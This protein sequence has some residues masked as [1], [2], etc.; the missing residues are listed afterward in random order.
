MAKITRLAAANIAG[1]NKVGFD[2]EIKSDAGTLTT[3]NANHE[4][5]ILPAGGM[6]FSYDS[7]DLFEPFEPIVSSRLDLSFFA[8]HD[9]QLDDIVAMNRAGEKS[10]YIKVTMWKNASVKQYWYGVLVPEETSYEVTDGRTLVR[11]KF[12]D[13][14]KMLG[15][16]E[17]TNNSTGELIEGWKTFLDYTNTILRKIPWVDEELSGV[18]DLIRETPFFETKDFYDSVGYSFAAD[19]GM[20]RKGGAIA[21]T[22]YKD[23][24]KASDGR[25]TVYS[26]TLSCEEV[27]RDICLNLGYKICWNGETFHFF[28]PLNYTDDTQGQV[29]HDSIL[30]QRDQAGSQTGTY[31][32]FEPEWDSDQDTKLMNGAMR[33]FSNC[34][35]E[36]IVTHKN[37]IASNII[38]SQ[39]GLNTESTTGGQNAHASKV[40]PDYRI[41]AGGRLSMR[42][43]A[44][45]DQRYD[46]TNENTPNRHYVYFAKVK[47]KVGNYYLAAPA[48]APA[49]M[50]AFELINAGGANNKLYPCMKR[51]LPEAY[52]TTTESYID[53]PMSVGYS[54][55]Q[56]TADEHLNG[57]NFI[58]HSVQHDGEGNYSV[59]N[60]R[61]LIRMDY[62]LVT[63]A[64]PTN[65]VGI[66]FDHGLGWSH[67][68]LTNNDGGNTIYNYNQIDN[69]SDY[70]T[71]IGTDEVVGYHNQTAFLYEGSQSDNP[72]FSSKNST[73][74]FVEVLD[75]GDVN[76]SARLNRNGN[77]GFI[78][79]LKHDGTYTFDTN[80]TT[81]LDRVTEERSNLQIL[82]EEW[83]RFAG[84][85]M[86]G[87]EGDFMFNPDTVK[88]FI[89]WADSILSSGCIIGGFQTADMLIN[90]FSYDLQGPMQISALVVDRDAGVVIV[91]NGRPEDGTGRPISPT[92]DGRTQTGGG[93]V[94]QT[95]LDEA[96]DQSDILSIFLSRNNPR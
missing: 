71:L 24:G 92:I 25:R 54:Y 14:L 55:M 53:I 77:A 22:F 56:P 75:L 94:S 19:G 51:D 79:M 70:Q 49:Y 65:S 4:I 9:D 33:V 34:Y 38:A 47:L 21:E 80:Y 30:Y 58:P 41:D 64:L 73:D 67:N 17:L 18:D 3:A 82:S 95:D 81:P 72:I 68:V 39:S 61:N 27:L 26:A 8:T 11:M 45:V 48:Q 96:K 59:D 31:D 50:D 86:E 88:T 91:D 85:G 78:S 87:L 74:D 57:A 6:V 76:L 5:Q 10:T 43:A 32:A 16:Y 93:G 28:S 7:G 20:L 62:T 63:P 90:E 44:T 52:W 89:P 12:A 35:N 83:Y 2:F 1:T 69:F 66:E 23:K 46:G 36:V 37:S 15:G 29:S 60:N 42:V 84:S 40:V 13:G